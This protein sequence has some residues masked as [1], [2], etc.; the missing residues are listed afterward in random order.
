MR[1]YAIL[2][3]SNLPATK[4]DTC[5]LLRRTHAEKSLQ[6]ETSRGL[7]KPALHVFAQLRSKQRAKGD[8]RSERKDFLGKSHASGAF[9]HGVQ[10]FDWRSRPSCKRPGTVRVIIVEDPMSAWGR[11]VGTVN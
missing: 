9:I 1:I 6:R 4:K 5:A 8:P 3:A 11:S 7:P 2:F 10:T